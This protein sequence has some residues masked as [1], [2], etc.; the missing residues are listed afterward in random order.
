[1]QYQGS[2]HCG[3]VSYEVNLEI[4]NLL[5][6]NCSICL[7]KGYLLAFTGINQF[8]L[9]KG[10]DQLTEYLFN[11][12]VIQHLFCKTCG[13]ASFGKGST[14]D[15]NKMVAINARCLDNIDLKK[16]PIMEYDGKHA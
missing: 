15:G 1:M 7:K 9:L 3:Q 2:C 10:E 12:K 4:E 6:C 14:P 11:K 13:V 8:K 16:F 5:S